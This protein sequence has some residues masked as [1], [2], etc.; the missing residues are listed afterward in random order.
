MACSYFLRCKKTLIDKYVYK[1]FLNSKRIEQNLLQL[2]FAVSSV[3]VL[4]Y[5]S[6]LV[7]KLGKIEK[8]TIWEEFE[9]EPEI[10]ERQGSDSST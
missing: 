5:S 6:E 9:V 4:V 8:K 2:L 10:I 3:Q 1:E 7:S